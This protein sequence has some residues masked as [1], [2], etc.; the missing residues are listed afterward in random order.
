MYNFMLKVTKLLRK[1]ENKCVYKIRMCLNK[2]LILNTIK[3]YEFFC[4]I[5]K[6]YQLNI[7]FA[8]L[9]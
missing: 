4:N 6:L 5:K 1:I 7:F 3:F 2:I 8:N 9:R